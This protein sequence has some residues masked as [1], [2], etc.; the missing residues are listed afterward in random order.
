[1]QAQYLSFFPKKEREKKKNLVKS[2]SVHGHWDPV[3]NNM[4]C[5]QE[6]FTLMYVRGQ[7]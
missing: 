7:I 4:W 3:E 6:V 5:E 2:R 1:M